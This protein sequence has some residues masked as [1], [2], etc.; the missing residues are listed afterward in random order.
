MKINELKFDVEKLRKQ[1]LFVATPMYGGMCYG[2]FTRSMIDL[3]RICTEN[4]I[5]LSYYFMYNESLIPRARNYCA[6][7]FLNQ[8]EVH[9]FL[10]I[11]SDI[12]FSG[13][14]VIEMLQMQIDNPDYDI[15]VGAYP[16]KTIAWEKIRAAV[17]Q[18]RADADPNELGRYVGDYVVNAVGDKP[19][20]ALN[21]PAEIA[22]GGTG[23]MMIR[24][25]TFEKYT[26][27]YPEYMYRPDH[28][29]TPGFDGSKEIMAFFHCDIDPQ[30]KRY[31][32]EDYWFCKMARDAGMKVWLCPWIELKHFGTYMYSGSLR[33]IASIGAPMTH[34]V[35]GELEKKRKK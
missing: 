23:F 18:G 17:Y 2:G 7:F 22:E 24:R 35:A 28:T 20:I 6:E 29:R 11:D 31:L 27:A 4:Q 33:D 12:E 13:M 34:D 16:K 5:P 25:E 3:T 19:T 8:K 15:M 1:G 30:S 14:S 10:F 26:K 32:S 9:S 21:E